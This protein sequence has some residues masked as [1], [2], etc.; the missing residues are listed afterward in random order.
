M[1][2]VATTRDSESGIV[3]LGRSSYGRNRG[4][5]L[6]AL[7]LT[8][9]CA[10]A[11]QNIFVNESQYRL[12]RGVLDGLLVLLWLISLIVFILRPLLNRYSAYA[13][14]ASSAG[15]VVLAFAFAYGAVA[16]WF[17]TGH[18]YFAAFVVSGFV[19][20]RIPRRVCW[21]Y[22]GSIALALSL[23]GFYARGAESF[24]SDLVYIL[25]PLALSEAAGQAVERIRFEGE[26]S[27]RD[28][29]SRNEELEELAYQDPLT[30]LY[31]RRYGFEGLRK[32]IS[33]ARR[34]GGELHILVLDI[35]RF[36]KVNDEL[37]HP[38]GDA[39][40][41]GLAK[42]LMGSLR[43]S[44]VAARIGGEEFLVI[45]PRARPEHAQSVANRIRDTMA[46]TS[47]ESV[48]WRVTVSIGVT[49]LRDDDTA[50]SIFSRADGFLYDSKRGGRNRVSGS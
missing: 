36:K 3:G 25:V 23:I 48:P 20:A 18:A 15:I 9:S 38:I 34:Y 11:S 32:N 16:S 50:E 4:I 14:F 37:G 10:L 6:S 43:D 42:I 17:G 13:R 31:N 41:T 26:I 44:D 12:V 49:S 2:E 22:E 19:I 5:I 1:V 8:G 35:D 27:L 24:R 45:L 21:V 29:K 46:R 47:F 28:L 30:Q 39:V 7:S 33:F 40:L